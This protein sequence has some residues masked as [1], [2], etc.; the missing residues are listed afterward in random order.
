MIDVYSGEQGYRLDLNASESG[1]AASDYGVSC[2]GVYVSFPAAIVSNGIL[3]I[4]I[5][6][7]RDGTDWDDVCFSEIE[8]WGT[9]NYDN[10]EYVT[11]DGVWSNNIPE[12]RLAN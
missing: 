1:Y 12:Y 3:R 2:A 9:S 11:G 5:A 4:T 10:V 6:D 8:L 7:V